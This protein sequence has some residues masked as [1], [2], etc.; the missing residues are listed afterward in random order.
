MSKFARLTT[1]LVD[2]MTAKASQLN[3]L[4]DQVLSASLD[5]ARIK[6]WGANTVN[7]LEQKLTLHYADL[8]TY[9]KSLESLKAVEADLQQ[10]Q[11]NLSLS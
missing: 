1:G 11:A 5:A 10:T 9:E 7:K 4:K 3:N 2:S 6:D 8:K